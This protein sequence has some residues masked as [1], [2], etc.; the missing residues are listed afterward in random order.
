MGIV[1]QTQLVVRN[2]RSCITTKELVKCCD[3]IKACQHRRGT[4]SFRTPNVADLP[5]TILFY[6]PSSA[7]LS[8]DKSKR[9][10]SS[11]ELTLLP[12]GIF[13]KLGSLTNL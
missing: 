9:Y 2:P 8:P 13:D 12:A 7:I 11:N 1:V 5:V 10:L 4:V 3:S 6:R